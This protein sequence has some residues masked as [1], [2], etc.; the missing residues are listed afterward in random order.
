MD[1][2]MDSIR[3]PGGRGGVHRGFTLTELMIA[4][5]VLV[6]VL[7]G[8][9]KIFSTSTKVTS[10]GE[11]NADVL[12]EAAAIE[13]QLRSDINQ[14]AHEGVFAI[15]CV[16][17]PN[18]VRGLNG[19][20]LN[21]A[22]P[23]DAIIR[24]D[25]LLFFKSG[26]ETT[27]TQYV[28]GSN[29]SGQTSQAQGT[30]S[31]VYY[32]H[33]YQ[34]GEEAPAAEP[35]FSQEFYWAI[36]HVWNDGLLYPWSFG[37]VEMDG[38]RFEG[39]TDYARRGSPVDVYLPPLDAREWLMVR[40][41]VALMD[42]NHGPS[43]QDTPGQSVFLGGVP[44][45]FSI[46]LYHEDR[47]DSPQVYHGRVDAAAST[48]EQVREMI[49]YDADG[50]RRLW[51]NPLGSDPD[52]WSIIQDELVYYPRAERYAPSMSRVDQALT[53]AVL[54]SAVSSI[55]IDWAYDE[56]VG[57]VRAPN[58]DLERAPGPDQ[59][60]PSDDYVLHGLLFCD[61]NN[62]ECGWEDFGDPVYARNNELAWFGMP[63]PARY[64]FNDEVYP[65]WNRGV[66]AY[67]DDQWADFD[68]GA[69]FVRPPSIY[70]QNIER[71]YK[72]TVGTLQEIAVYEAFFG[73]NRDYPIVDDPRSSEAGNPTP[74]LGYTPWPSAI[75]VTLTM[76][77]PNGSLETGREVQFIIDL[78]KRTENEQ[79]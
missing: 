37:I 44:S 22:L 45:A 43:M 61:L 72:S 14:L 31:R 6:V 76:H 64:L 34:F 69:G 1:R 10:L 5:A 63:D 19:P 52:Q 21:P 75:R 32:G 68:V 4:V 55:E 71:L 25:Q 3:H 79:S 46:F 20:L 35:N 56:G 41:P 38:T 50:D 28:G 66:G 27:Q 29:P 16:A 58:G 73:F 39:S 62:D 42:D 11:A 40:Q 70:P 9:S 2:F 74:N 36:D 18:D 17:V 26:T 54:G 24:C 78:P 51:N 67:S 53:T 57:E 33:S 49:Q 23:R 59:A 47:A 65:D 77:D 12:Q 8:V 7:L 60:S 13:Q 30:I 48:M 15:R